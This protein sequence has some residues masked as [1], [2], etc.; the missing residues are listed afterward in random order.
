MLHRFTADIIDSGL[1]VLYS[2]AGVKRPL[3][4][5]LKIGLQDP[6]SLYAGKKVLQNA[7]RGAF[8]NTFYL[9]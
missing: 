3:S 8:C 2:K 1:F 5:R 9:Q 4:K 7:P 6:L